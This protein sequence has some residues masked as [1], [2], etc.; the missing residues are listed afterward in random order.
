[1]PKAYQLGVTEREVVEP[2]CLTACGPIR[3]T[4]DVPSAADVNAI[5]ADP[6]TADV[7]T[8]ESLSAATYGDLATAGP[9][10][11]LSLVNGQ[12]CLVCVQYQQTAASGAGTNA[13]MSFAVS[14]AG[15]LAA[16]DVN[17]AIMSAG[18]GEQRGTERWTVFTAGATGSFTF[19]AK[20]RSGMAATTVHF[21][22]RRILAKKF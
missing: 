21:V 6:V 16:A 11:T 3:A 2:T 5:T 14:G 20:Y 1:M 10:V 22:N 18:V 9:A 15:T 17:A 7:S 12:T 8:D 19:T 4:N 13:L